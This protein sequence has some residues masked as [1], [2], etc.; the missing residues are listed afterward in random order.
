MS[1]DDDYGDEIDTRSN[2]KKSE[3]MDHPHLHALTDL[4]ISSGKSRELFSGVD[5]RIVFTLLRKPV[6]RWLRE[7]FKPANKGIPASLETC[8]VAANNLLFLLRDHS[9]RQIS[10]GD[11]EWLVLVPYIFSMICVPDNASL[12]AQFITALSAVDPM[13]IDDLGLTDFVKE[14]GK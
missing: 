4:C 14:G 1:S 11:R 9:D 7:E 6:L 13:F 5:L 2:F 10:Y 3:S 12:P 8:E